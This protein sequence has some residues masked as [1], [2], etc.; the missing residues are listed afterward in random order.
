MSWRKDKYIVVI[1]YGV[2]QVITTASRGFIQQFVVSPQSNDTVW[3]MSILDRDQDCIYSI[4]DQEGPLNDRQGL[5]VGKD[6][7][8]K[9]TI[10]FYELTKNEPMKVIFNIQELQ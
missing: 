5:S 4:K 7:M 3:S 10:Q 9:L 6:Q 1:Q 8:E 2:G